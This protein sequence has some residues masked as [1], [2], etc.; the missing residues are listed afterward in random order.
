[1]FQ[2]IAAGAGAVALILG[3][4]TVTQHRT[5]ERH[6]LTI[7]ALKDQVSDKDATISAQSTGIAEMIKTATEAEKGMKAA[8]DLIESL[9][10]DIARERARR[11]ATVEK[12]Y[13]L[14][15]CAAL[16]AL[17]LAGVCPAH[18]GRV[19]DAAAIP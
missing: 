19:R 6:E 3:V 13:A 10:T 17:D 16:L 14:P 18:A 2:Y 7:G 5:I 4:V 12:D 8:G 9:N 1:M 11:A 15:D